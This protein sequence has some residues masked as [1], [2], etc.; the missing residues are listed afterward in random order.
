M[1]FQINELKEARRL[2]SEITVKGAQVYDLLG[3]E[4]D[5]RVKKKLYYLSMSMLY[6]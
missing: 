1:Y 2:A 5:L 4:V 6:E 3:K